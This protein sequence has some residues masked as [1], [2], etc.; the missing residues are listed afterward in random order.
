MESIKPSSSVTV[1]SQPASLCSTFVVATPIRLGLPLRLHLWFRYTV[2]RCGRHFGRCNVGG[3]ESSNRPIKKPQP[4]CQEQLAKDDLRTYG[5]E[6]QHGASPIVATLAHLAGIVA[7]PCRV[8]LQGRGNKGSPMQLNK[9][10]NR[11]SAVSA[12]AEWGAAAPRTTTTCMT[13]MLRGAGRRRLLARNYLTAQLGGDI[14]ARRWDTFCL[15]CDRIP[16]LS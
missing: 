13:P 2:K 15:P 9:G 7:V 6:L 8:S 16:S 14:L 10:V 4:D 5:D 3:N 12:E 11:Q 1:T